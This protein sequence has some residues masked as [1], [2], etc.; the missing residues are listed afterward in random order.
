VD[1][2]PRRARAHRQPVRRPGASLT[3]G[4]N[5]LQVPV[6]RRG[7]VKVSQG[8]GCSWLGLLALRGRGECACAG[9][10]RVWRE[11]GYWWC[12]R[13]LTSFFLGGPAPVNQYDAGSCL[14]G[15]AS[16][17]RARGP[18]NPS[19]ASAVPLAQVS[20]YRQRHISCVP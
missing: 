17:L 2:R 1:H 13:P 8:A 6:G 3:V 4:P 20:Q 19:E 11:G 9:S 16:A 10:L 14:E 15:F 7:G 18:D 5:Q 12:G